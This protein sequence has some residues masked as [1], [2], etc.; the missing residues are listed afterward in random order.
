[1]STKIVLRVPAFGNKRQVLRRSR[2]MVM[3]ENLILAVVCD[4]VIHRPGGH[5]SSGGNSF[6]VSSSWHLAETP[7]CKEA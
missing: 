6:W 5:S 3:D 2:K 7:S 1:M 4:M